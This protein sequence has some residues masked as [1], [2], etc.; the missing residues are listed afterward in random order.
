MKKYIG[1]LLTLICVLMASSALALTEFEWNIRC[2]YKTTGTTTLYDCYYEE[3]VASGTDI[4]VG[5]YHF[6]PRGSLPAGT[7]IKVASLG[8]EGKEEIMYYSNGSVLYAY[9]DSGNMTRATVTV[10]ASNGEKYA[11][12]EVCYANPATWHIVLT[13]NFGESHAKVL[14]DALERGGYSDGEGGSSEKKAT[15]VRMGVNW[16]D[17]NGEEQPVTLDTLG[18]AVSVIVLNKEKMTV[19]TADLRWDT[20]A[21]ADEMLAVV[22]AHNS[23][24]ASLRDKASTKGNVIKKVTTNRIVLVMEKGK[25]FTKVLCDG[26]VGYIIN[27]ALTYYPVGGIAEGEAEPQPGWVSFRGKLNSRNTVNIR[28]NG[29]NGSRILTDFIAGTPI[30]V[31]SQEGKW[32]EI[33][34]GGYRAYILSE[35]VTLD[36]GTITEE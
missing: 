8:L 5:T 17:E 11:V 6:E 1:L 32:S 28:Q 20:T 24:K 35:Y 21:E 9:I 14:I 13:E 26:M 3:T 34:V 19:P 22:K 36:D 7:Y 31:F 33:D 16:V 2:G 4:P 10:Q 12:P 23:G 30:M 29:K 27:T 25:T 15:I 18:T